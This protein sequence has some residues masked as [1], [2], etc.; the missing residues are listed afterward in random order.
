MDP[1]GKAPEDGTGSSG[2]CAASLRD[3][4]T[5]T[6]GPR[7]PGLPERLAPWG[8]TGGG[9]GRSRTL[10]RSW[11][12]PRSEELCCSC[13][14][15]STRAERRT[16]EGPLEGGPGR[17]KE[18]RSRVCLDRLLQEALGVQGRRQS[19]EGTLQGAPPSPGCGCC[20]HCPHPPGGTLALSWGP[21]RPAS[22]R[23]HVHTGGELTCNRIGITYQVFSS[24]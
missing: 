12:C 22:R 4:R 8:P 14:G 9:P 2:G 16:V 15:G 19:D 20:P 13:L 23:C 1:R 24:V 6:C 10:T 21:T 18:G 5:R 17:A 3:R 11:P 7:A